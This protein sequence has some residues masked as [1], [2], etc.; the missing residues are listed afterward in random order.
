MGPFV[1]GK[2][3]E[4]SGIRTSAEGSSEEDGKFEE[5]GGTRSAFGYV[6]AATNRMDIRTYL[7]IKIIA[8]AYASIKLTL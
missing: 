8:V 7:L 5:V 2:G 3:S 6:E 1:K 4:R